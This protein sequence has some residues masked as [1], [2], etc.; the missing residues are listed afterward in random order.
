VTSAG[1]NAKAGKTEQGSFNR[2]AANQVEDNRIYIRTSIAA[3]LAFLS[4]GMPSFRSTT[5]AIKQIGKTDIRSCSLSRLE[6]AW[7]RS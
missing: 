6:L 3:Y 1:N 5:I 7:Q 4:W 2:L